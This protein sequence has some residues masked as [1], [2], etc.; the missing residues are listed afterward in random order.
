MCSQNVI[1]QNLVLPRQENP[2]SQVLI[3]CVH[4][5]QLPYPVATVHLNWKGDDEVITVGV[6]PNLGED[7]ILGTDYVGFTS[8]L[9]K[10]GQEHINNTWWEEA[11]FGASEEETRKPRIK[12]SRKQKREQQRVHQSLRDPRKPESNSPPAMICTTS[13]DLRQGQHDDPTLKNAW[14]QALQPDGQVAGLRRTETPVIA[15]RKADNGGAVSSGAGGRN[16]ADQRKREGEEEADEETDF[17]ASQE[18][19]RDPTSHASGEAWQ[20]QVRA[21]SRE[22]GHK[23]E[24]EVGRRKEETPRGS[25]RSGEDRN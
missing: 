25:R 6:I 15:R 2:Q 5:D 1:R 13:G 9:E 16:S 10:A 14:H 22:K 8:L 18:A 11:P 7:L 24:R 12:L 3:A 20:S 19:E 21:G 4:G 23:R 17:S